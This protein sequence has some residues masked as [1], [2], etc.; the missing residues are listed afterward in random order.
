MA[1]DNRTA[2]FLPVSVGRHKHTAPVAAGDYGL[3]D[4]QILYHARRQD[5]V[6][7]PYSVIARRN[8]LADD[9]MSVA[10]EHAFKVANRIP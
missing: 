9:V 2:F 10:V 1:V 5:A 4:G 7:E 3:V 8:P 6:E